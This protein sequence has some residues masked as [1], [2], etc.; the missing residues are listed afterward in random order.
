M[1]RIEGK[2]NVYTKE[3]KKPNSRRDSLRFAVVG[4]SPRNFMGAAEKF[5]VVGDMREL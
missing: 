4:Q 2:K 1:S 5:D 3:R